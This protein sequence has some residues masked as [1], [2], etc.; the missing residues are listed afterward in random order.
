VSKKSIILVALSA[1]MSSA[2]WANTTA[3]I[4]PSA[5]ITNN[6]LINGNSLSFGA[7]DPLGGAAVTATTTISVQ[8]TNGMSAPTITLDQGSNPASGST[9]GAPKRQL[10]NTLGSGSTNNLT[11]NLYTD[12][13]YGT[14]WDG[15]T[16]VVW[17]QTPNGTA[18]TMTVYGKIDANQHT[19]VA[20]TYNDTV[21]ATVTF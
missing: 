16:G 11:Y 14:V 12:G 20:A 9:L 8:C 13:T 1:W 4:T 10:N 18:Q 6:C 5:T 21:T 17:N 3:S 7:Y 15:V 2:A 19:A